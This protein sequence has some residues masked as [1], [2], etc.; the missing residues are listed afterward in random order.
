MPLNLRSTPNGVLVS[1]Y[2]R[3]SAR[4]DGIEVTDEIVVH[5]REPAEDNRANLAV[6]KLLS[7]AL[8]VPRSSVSIVRGTTSRV[9][10]LYISGVTADHFTRLNSK[11]G[12]E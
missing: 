2:V 10:E 4:R 11:S 9:K 12:I 5:T 7:K 6:M 3:P 8:G 1:V